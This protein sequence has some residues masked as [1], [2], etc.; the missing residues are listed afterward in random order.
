MN[1]RVE[2]VFHEVADLPFEARVQYFTEHAVEEETQREVEGLIA[3]DAGATASFER[4]IGEL[5]KQIIAPNDETRMRCGA[6]QLNSLLGRGGMGEVYLAE[7]VDGEV[8]HQAAVKLLSRSSDHPELRKRFLVERQILATISHPN[9]AR[10]LDAGHRADGQPY[11]VM[12]YVEGKPIDAFTAGLTIRQKISLFLKVCSAVGY[13]HRNLVV[14]RDL[15]P[16]NIFVTNEGEPKV[17]DFGIAK[18]LNLL[19]DSD[20]TSVRILTPDYASPEQI[21]GSPVTTASDV[22]SLGAVLYK[23]LTATSPHQF[24]RD[25]DGAMTSVIPVRKITPL[26][27]VVPALKGDLE[28]VVMKALRSDPQ[29]RYATVEQLA[30]DL[31]SYLDSRPIRARKSDTWYRARK[32][33]RRHWV[34]LAATALVMTSLLSGLYIANR[35]RVIAERRFSQLR[36]LS[37]K[38]IDLDVAIRTLPGATDARRRLV[39]ASLDYLEGLSHEASGNLDLAQEIADGYW[40]MARIQGVNAEFNLGD[41]SKAE[42]SLKKADA[43]IDMVLASR[44]RDRSSI[45]RSALIAHDRMIL[46]DTEERR[47][48]TLAHTR[49]AVERLEAFSRQNGVPNKPVHL[50]GFFRSGDAQ[51]AERS[52]VALLYLNIA[53]T[54]VNLHMYADGAR[55]AQRGAEIAQSVPAAQDLASGSL[56]L[57]ANALRYQGDAEGALKTIRRAREI[58]EKAIYP[59]ET[60]RFFNRYGPMF[61]E[62]LI[63]GEADAINAGR[64]AEA[65]DVFQKTLELTEE[66]VR[67]DANDAASRSRAASTARELGDLL[68]ERDPQRSLAVYD[69]GIK[70]LEEIKNG[71]KANRDHATLLAKSSY[72][73]RRLHRTAEARERI[74]AAF[75][76]LQQTKDYPANRILLGSHAY[77]ALCALGDYQ[78]DVG[79]PEG[80]IKT[81]RQLLDGVLAAHPDVN[82]DLRD[83][84]KLSR[85]YE[86]L[87][88]L[89]RRTADL[90][91]NAAVK[92]QSVRLWEHWQHRLPQNTFIQTQLAAAGRL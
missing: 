54:Y 44:P 11:L 52:G 31:E 32:F 15:K 51:Q 67:R 71:R 64:P 23:L 45:F 87:A 18:V 28:I 37:K 20:V 66:A 13:L 43:L 29:E 39:S 49:R 47:P 10:L 92:L 81:Y 9:V 41:P 50:E 74:D 16:G 48:D 33:L 30:E 89:Y 56:S 80:A 19:A 68:R 55:F 3:F 8:K 35:E 65:I 77:T 25:S 17:L 60:T 2:K 5:A 4:D 26:S 57:L 70:R 21:A 76:I 78:A 63:L 42:V 79:N 69:L 58:S 1:L 61:R 24:E 36:Q 40:R 83:A 46:A 73:L 72:P 91:A 22:Y 90:S 75:A 38:V 85:I 7:R 53:L 12:E 86:A 88:T 14:H 82:G 27:K 6:Y 59:S 62:G 34:P 84:P